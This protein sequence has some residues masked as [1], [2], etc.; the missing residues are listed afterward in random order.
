LIGYQE[1]ET[2]TYMYGWCMAVYKTFICRNKYILL[3]NRSFETLSAVLDCLFSQLWD[4]HKSGCEIEKGKRRCSLK[5]YYLLFASCNRASLTVCIF[6]FLHL[7]NFKPKLISLSLSLRCADVKYNGFPTGNP[8]N[9]G[10]VGRFK[11]VFFH[12][13]FH[14]HSIIL[15]SDNGNNRKIV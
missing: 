3:L 8:Q 14:S 10:F 6:N 13:H 12:S 1:P 9:W 15:L 11:T 4:F 5:S 7:T 2:H